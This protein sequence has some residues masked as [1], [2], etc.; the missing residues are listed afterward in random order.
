MAD[1][2]GSAPSCDR[3]VGVKKR[4]K[5]TSVEQ[6]AYKMARSINGVSDTIREGAAAKVEAA[7]VALRYKII[8][9]M[10]LPV[11]DRNLRME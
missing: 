4:K 8:I 7:S 3:P 6:G 11:A 9:I 2:S 5:E 10:G 1:I